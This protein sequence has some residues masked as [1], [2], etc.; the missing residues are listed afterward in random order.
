MKESLQEKS[1]HK[2]IR[3]IILMAIL[4]VLTS[5]YF[6]WT[7]RIWEYDLRIPFP[8]S[9]GD[10][11]FFSGIVKGI[12][13]NGWYT[14]NPFLGAPFGRELYDFP[15]YSDFGNILQIKFLTLFFDNYAYLINFLAYIVFP[16]TALTT[17]WV[18]DKLSI[19]EVCSFG[20][21][22]CYS[23]SIFRIHRLNI[24]HFFLTEY[25]LI[26]IAILLLIWL[27]EDEHFF[28]LEKGLFRYKRNWFGLLILLFF[29][30]K[31]VY[32]TFFTCFFVCVIILSRLIYK[33]KLKAAVPGCMALCSMV[34]PLLLSYVPSFFYQ[35]AN[36]KNPLSPGRSPFET[37]E[38]SLEITGLFLNPHPKIPGGEK[39]L[40]SYIPITINIGSC[41]IGIVGILGFIIL[42]FIPFIKSKNTLQKQE[43]LLEDRISWM[44]HLLIFTLL[45][46]VVGGGGA[47]FSAFI[48]PQLRAYERISIFIYFFCLVGFCLFI[49]FIF[50]VLK[51]KK[52]ACRMVMVVVTGIFLLALW[53]QSFFRTSGTYDWTKEEFSSDKHFVQMIESSV[54]ENAMILQLPYQQFPEMPPVENMQDYSHTRGYLHSDTLRWSY[55]AYKGRQTDHI[56]MEMTGKPINEMVEQAREMGFQGIYVDTQGYKEEDLPAL[57]HA[58]NESL[59]SEK[60]ISENWRLW[61]W[62]IT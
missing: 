50:R 10:G 15:V 61:F 21:A 7:Y 56:L 27:I 32:Y 9:M 51:D 19:S 54:E 23:F 31:G 53:E 42:I 35:R 28:Q 58:L 41:Y 55:G 60:Q 25:S 20:G 4:F 3:R 44:R 43:N 29:S 24:G 49:T 16:M 6:F 5:L 48:T 39:L 30:V 57:E 2:K 26:P 11:M 62:K 59:G 22:F 37:Q 1:R 52:T 34:F 45:L 13:D 17:Y 46:S 38:Y 14:E 33:K 36:G 8:Y 47:A 18:L 40:D 12:T